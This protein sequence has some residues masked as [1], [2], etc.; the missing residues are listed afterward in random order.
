[1]KSADHDVLGAFCSGH[2][3]LDLFNM[4]EKKQVLLQ[5][6][7]REGEGQPWSLEVIRKFG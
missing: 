4:W 3:C 2:A 5:I 6:S 1:M 7:Q